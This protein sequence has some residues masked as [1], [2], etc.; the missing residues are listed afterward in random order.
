M[1][2]QRCALKFE[3]YSYNTGKVRLY[4][5]HTGIVFEDEDV[6]LPDFEVRKR[7]TANIR[8]ATLNG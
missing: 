7:N 4:W 6:R 2:V 5:F 3:S 1:D 8:Y